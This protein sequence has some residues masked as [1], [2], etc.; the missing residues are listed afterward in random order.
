MTQCIAKRPLIHFCRL[1]G[2]RMDRSTI[3]C[4]NVLCVSI[5]LAWRDTSVDPV[6]NTKWCC[7][8]G[9]LTV[10]EV[11]AVTGVPPTPA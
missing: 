9:G 4:M 2:D 7:C 3:L 1:A 11:T 6:E 8:T 10:D 5:V